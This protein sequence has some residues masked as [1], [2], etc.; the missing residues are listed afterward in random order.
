MNVVKRVLGMPTKKQKERMLEY[1]VEAINLSGM[2]TTP[3]KREILQGI[4]STY[5]L[6]E[7]T[8]LVLLMDKYYPES[9]QRSRQN[10]PRVDM[11]INVAKRNGYSDVAILFFKDGKKYFRSAAADKS[12]KKFGK[13]LKLYE[14]GGQLYTIVDGLEPLQRMI[15]T[16][17][18]EMIAANRNYGHRKPIIQ[19][20]QP[21]TRGQGGN[22]NEMLLSYHFDS[23]RLNYDHVTISE[24]RFGFKPQDRDS[25]KLKLWVKKE[26]VEIPF[27]LN[28]PFLENNL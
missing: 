3:R 4:E 27:I 2:K 8:G 23:V 5:I 18:E 21:D 24:K 13:S 11:F 19:Y 6:V 25:D 28:S 15:L 20:Y 16:R 17:P 1:L 9:K 26:K 7:K 14:K 10:Q 12:W 22:L